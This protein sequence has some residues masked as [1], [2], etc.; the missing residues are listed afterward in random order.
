MR[1]LL[2]TLALW[3]SLAF[4]QTIGSSGG[5]GGGTGTVTSV[6]VTTANGVSGS[7]ANPT[8]T[9]AI[10][11]TLGD[12]TPTSVTIGSGAI[13]TG[14]AAATLQYGAADVNGAPVAQTIKFQNALAGSATNTASPNA[15]IIGALGTGTGTN[16]NI[17]FQVGVKTTTGS[18]QATPTT[19]L[20]ITGETLAITA[21]GAVTAGATVSG[22]SVTSSATGTINWTGRA[23]FT[24]PAA[25]TTQFGFADAV[26]P[27][28]QILQAQSAT[29]T[30]IAGVSLT[31]NG[32]R[33]TGSGVSGDV[34]FQTGGTGAGSSAQ[35]AF[36]TALTLKGA[37]QSVVLNT[38]AVATNATDGF[39][40]IAS[41]AGTP[42][43]VP[44]TFTGR[45]PIYI[46]TTNS[47]LWLFLGGAWKQ[48]KTPAGAALVTW[49]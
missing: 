27:T 20:T 47:Q 14:S 22:S 48:P 23:A 43:G 2:L 28:A 44:T 4:G 35:N 21:A 45:V 36:V 15:T 17:I 10:T 6:S 38:A 34:I 16:G 49:Q 25:A 8:T 33:S 9:P 32:S 24:S 30:N 26:G 40:Y 31:I 7:V 11:V 46:D 29:G 5:G 19:A 18:V 39:L 42:T 1:K 13:L 37:T 3:P 12:I 41:G